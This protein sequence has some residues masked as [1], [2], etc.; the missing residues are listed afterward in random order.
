MNFG[1]DK[2]TCIEDLRRVAKF[3]VPKMFY[4]YADSGS[5]TEST[6]RANS[7]DFNE[8]KF[9][10]KV[11]VDME[12]RSLAT[13]MVGQ[14]VTMP[15]ALAPTGLTGMQR[16]EAGYQGTV[17]RRG[18]SGLRIPGRPTVLRIRDDGR[19][20][21]DSLGLGT[22]RLH[23]GNDLG[24]RIPWLRDRIQRLRGRHGVLRLHFS[25]GPL[26]L[27]AGVLRRDCMRQ[28]FRVRLVYDGA[29]P[30]TNGSR[31][32][33]GGKW[34]AFTG[35]LVYD[36]TTP[37]TDRGRCGRTGRRG[38]S[39]GILVYDG[40]TPLADGGCARLDIRRPFASRLIDDGTTTTDTGFLGHRVGFLGE[41]APRGQLRTPPPLGQGLSGRSLLHRKRSTDPLG[42]V[43]NIAQSRT[44]NTRH[45]TGCGN[46]LTE[47][48]L[49]T[50]PERSSIRHRRVQPRR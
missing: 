31:R 43:Q 6:Y 46:T 36:G 19:R 18:G 4:D 21:P 47:L 7:R 8:I 37:M 41:I 16:G 39:I 13:K 33:R 15:V 38:T 45:G 26:L 34:R 1:L 9:R 3:K 35:I 11:L 12:G 50:P 17:V 32:G 28:V 20:R 30:L 10:Q 23:P 49:R 24:A 5:W 22:R 25:D 29:T 14:D 44:G 2:M 48:R 40:T 27:A 42:V